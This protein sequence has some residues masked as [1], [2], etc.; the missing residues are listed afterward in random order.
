MSFTNYF[1]DNLFFLLNKYISLND[2]VV[3]ERIYFTKWQSGIRTEVKLIK[4]IRNYK[5]IIFVTSNVWN[6]HV[7]YVGF[8]S[9]L[10]IV[11]FMSSPSSPLTFQHTDGVTAKTG[12]QKGKFVNASCMTTTVRYILTMQTY[13][14]RSN[15]LLNICKTLN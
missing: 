4:L 12:I 5:E 14:T 11:S 9:P 6:K 15:T 2:R 7:S 13:N 1:L 8:L 3:S 10:S